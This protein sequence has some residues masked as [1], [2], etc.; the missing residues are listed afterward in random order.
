MSLAILLWRLL[1][2]YL[3]ILVGGIFTATAGVWQKAK[4]SRSGKGKQISAS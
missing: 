2:F 1:T 4:P 3:P